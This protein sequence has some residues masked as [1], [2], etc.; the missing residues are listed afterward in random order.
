MIQQRTRTARSTVPRSAPFRDTRRSAP[1]PA[2]TR[3]E[4]LARQQRQQRLREKE[5]ES[6]EPQA[7]SAGGGKRKWV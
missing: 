2:L 5:Q 4:A 6:R 7:A 3:E 1:R